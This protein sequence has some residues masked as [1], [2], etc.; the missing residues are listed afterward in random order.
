MEN[1]GR[2][3]SGPPNIASDSDAVAEQFA[4]YT[5][6]VITNHVV[7]NFGISDQWGDKYPLG[8][9]TG[10]YDRGNCPPP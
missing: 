10:R 7:R 9:L 8:S 5:V 3:H 6:L 1:A 2:S 4:L